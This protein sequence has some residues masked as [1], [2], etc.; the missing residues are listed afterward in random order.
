LKIKHYTQQRVKLIAGLSQF[1]KALADFLFVIY[2]LTLVL[3]TRN[4][5]YTNTLANINQKHKMKKI[6]TLMKKALLIITLFIGIGNVNAQSD[7]TKEETLNWLNTYW[8]KL[9]YQEMMESNNNIYTKLYIAIDHNGKRDLALDMRND[10][11]SKR[12][13]MN[14]NL[15]SVTKI[16]LAPLQ[17]NGYKISIIT[18]TQ[19][20]EF[21]EIND[22]E[23]TRKWKG[24]SFVTNFS[25]QTDAF[26]VFKALK[27]LYTFYN[28]KVEFVDK[29]SIENKF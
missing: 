24:Y 29:V 1:T 3:K 25:K 14:T 9:S 15:N 5:S 26:R 22:D 7:A 12:I 20:V 2:L 8:I 18:D 17:K 4:K 11:Y 19:S 28:Y 23:D 10:A 27:H 13:Y 21:M 16:Q 6:N